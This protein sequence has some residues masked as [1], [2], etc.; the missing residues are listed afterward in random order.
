[1]IRLFVGI[2]GS[3]KTKKLIDAVNDALAVSE[4]NVVCVENGDFL[5]FQLSYK[6]RLVPASNYGIA[7]FDTLYGFLAGICA[8]DHDITDVFVDGT[9][10]IAGSKDV[11]GV[12][13]FLDKINKLGE[14]SG[15]RFTLT[16]SIDPDTLP[17]NVRDFCE[18]S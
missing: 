17:A 10:R 9:F 15:T 2:K 1:M 4:G 8:G 16:L 5:R 3:G 7:G 14:L 12:C 13:V 11:E 6:V 18:I